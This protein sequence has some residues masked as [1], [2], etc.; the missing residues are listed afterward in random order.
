VQEQQTS[1]IEWAL[2][3]T[4]S[5]MDGKRYQIS[6][7]SHI[8]GRSTEA[9]ITLPS[10]HLS[11][12]HAELFRTGDTLTVSDLSSTNG[13]FINGKAVD[14]ATIIAG[15]QLR[16][17][18]FTFL[19]EGPDLAEEPTTMSSEAVGGAKISAVHRPT[20]PGNREEAPQKPYAI[21]LK[22]ISALL[23]A[24]ALAYL[25]YLLLQI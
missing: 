24:G 11:R 1:D 19:I 8:I 7:G 6:E 18:N 15:D 9:D 16:L 10:T 12:Q 2:V 17:D 23:I 21:G 22:I 3:A 25:G 13:T 5:W 4:G 14:K 20:S